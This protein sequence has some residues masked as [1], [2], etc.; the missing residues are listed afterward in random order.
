M[1]ELLSSKCADGHTWT[2]ADRPKGGWSTNM[3]DGG[4]NSVLCVPPHQGC[5]GAALG[6]L[7]ASKQRRTGRVYGFT[8]LRGNQEEGGGGDAHPRIKTSPEKNTK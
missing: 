3:S 8:D 6:Q 1:G 5:S 2:D 4:P 7:W